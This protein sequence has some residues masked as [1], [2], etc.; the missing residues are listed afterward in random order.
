MRIWIV[1]SKNIEPLRNRAFYKRIEYLA[2]HHETHLLVPSGVQI[3]PILVQ[4]LRVERAP[5]FKIQIFSSLPNKLRR[6]LSEYYQIMA[7]YRWVLKRLDEDSI[8]KANDVVYTFQNLDAHAGYL[9]S[10]HGYTWIVDILDMPDL[11][12]ESADRFIKQGRYFSA[13]FIH[14][15]FLHILKMKKAFRFADMVF[16]TSPSIDT[17]FAWRMIN[18]YGVNPEKVVLTRNGVD[19]RLCKPTG[20]LHPEH[21]IK[22]FVVFYVGTLAPERGTDLIIETMAR[23]K[24]FAPDVSLVLAG[25]LLPGYLESLN[26][27]ILVLGLENRVFM[28]G[29]ISHEEVLAWIENSQICVYPFLNTK[30]LNGVF[31]IKLLEYLALGKA[32]VAS[33]LTGVRAI[34]KHGLNGLIA[35]A[36]NLSDWVDSIESLY[37]N[38]F[39]RQRLESEARKS[40][41]AYDWN[42]INADIDHH[43][44]AY[45]ERKFSSRESDKTD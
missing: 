22:G 5:T 2:S 10:R 26:K 18:E 4:K 19:L 35:Q 40:V 7:F 3:D 42:T 33:D 8:I 39:L 23:L 43:L 21:S 41:Q 37:K 31:P 9:A 11:Y 24:T 44:K 1:W 36:G 16:I 14:L 20:R 15:F 6:N 27:R 28:L 13:I 25:N 12:L 17:G 34:I 45:V 38:K 29:N 32:C 30:R